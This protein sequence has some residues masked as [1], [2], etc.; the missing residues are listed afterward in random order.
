MNRNG[1]CFG[2]KVAT[3]DKIFKIRVMLH[4]K[5]SIANTMMIL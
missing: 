4:K 2:K 1:V 5:T 3:N